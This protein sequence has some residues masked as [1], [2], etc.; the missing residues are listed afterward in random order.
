MSLKTGA[1]PSGV[2][3]VIETSDDNA[4]WRAA[5]GELTIATWNMESKPVSGA[6]R[7]LRVRFLNS[8]SAPVARFQLFELE[9][10]GAGGGGTSGNR[11]PVVSG[12]TADRYKSPEYLTA[13]ASDPDGDMLT[14]TWARQ[15]GTVFGEGKTVHYYG[16]G[17][18][19]YDPVKDEPVTVTVRDGRGGVAT[20]DYRV[21]NFGGNYAQYPAASA[22]EWDPGKVGYAYVPGDV[23]VHA[24]GDFAAYSAVILEYATAN[25]RELALAAAGDTTLPGCTG[26][27]YMYLLGPT[28][29]DAPQPR[30]TLTLTAGGKTETRTITQSQVAGT[31]HQGFIVNGGPGAAGTTL[32]ETSARNGDRPYKA[33]LNIFTSGYR[34]PADDPGNYAPYSIRYQIA[35]EGDNV[36]GV[37]SRYCYGDCDSRLIFTDSAGGAADNTGYW[38]LYEIYADYAN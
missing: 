30:I 13:N 37:D 5:S 31:N 15:D 23:T 2:R 29:S 8:A 14:Y 26:A 4:H 20:Y 19:N 1:L 21:D 12:V 34:D 9:A 28:G 27:V 7:Y 22:V 24:S 33:M 35:R 10:Y 17:G 18:E 6:G 25:G 11:A 3:F 38:G 32:G 16:V 36:F